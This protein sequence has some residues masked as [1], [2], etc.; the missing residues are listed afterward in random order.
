MKKNYLLILI[1]TLLLPLIGSNNAMAAT[2]VSDAE[3]LILDKMRAGAEMNGEIKYLPVAYLNQAEN[4]FISN[5]VDLTV[6]QAELII[7]KIDDAVDIISEL[8]TV[9]MVNIQNSEVALQLLTLV[10][11]VATE[12]DYEVSVD[13]ANRSINVRNPEGNTV[14]IA[15]NGI[16][17]TGKSVSPAMWVVSGL[18]IAVLVL[19][20]RSKTIGAIYEK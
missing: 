2:G 11:E 13:I 6:E 5:K 1:V 15:K 19:C 16:N 18:V 9:D 10:S 3:Q 17:Q 4:E 20:V 12:V 8:D 14:F 7:S